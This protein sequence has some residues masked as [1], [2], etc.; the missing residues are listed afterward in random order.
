MKIRGQLPQ[1]VLDELSGVH[2]HIDVKPPASDPA[3]GSTQQPSD[4]PAATPTAR[5]RQL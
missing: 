5:R 3:G 1:R 4:D 2:E